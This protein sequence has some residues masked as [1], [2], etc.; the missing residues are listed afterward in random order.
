MQEQPRAAMYMRVAGESQ[1]NTSNTEEKKNSLKNA[2]THKSLTKSTKML[3]FL[4]NEAEKQDE[5]PSLT[6]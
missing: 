2:K 5:S 6:I 3:L 4:F 1:L